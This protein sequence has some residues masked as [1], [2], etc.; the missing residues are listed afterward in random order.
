M[1]ATD[2]EIAD[3]LDYTLAPAN[4]SAEVFEQMMDDATKKAKILTKVIQSQSDKYVVHAAGQEFLRFEAWSTLARG[5]GWT[6]GVETITDVL[7]TDGHTVIGVEAYAVLRDSTGT[8]IGGAP[9]R[10]MLDEPNWSNKPLA[11]VASMAGTRAASKALRIGLSWVVVLAG[12][13]PTPAEEF[14]RDASGEIVV[15]SRTTSTQTTRKRTES[16]NKGVVTDE[17]ASESEEDLICPLH[18]V[19]FFKRGRMKSYAHPMKDIDGSGNWCNRHDVQAVTP[20]PAPAPPQIPT[21]VEEPRRAVPE[22]PE[23]RPDDAQTVSEPAHET[24]EEPDLILVAADE[25]E[26]ADLD[27]RAMVAEAGMEWDDFINKVLPANVTLETFIEMGG[28]VDI[29]KARI[30]NMNK[31]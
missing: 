1:V 5:Y 14:E 24:I 29:A 13:N 15:S 7:D 10:C 22:G 3:R 4:L 27:Y 17:V 19:E 20:A 16:R 12:Y 25:D 9:A 11:Q 28:T 23:D 6:A 2:I 30:A 8:Q 26:P 31:G 18:N 21:P